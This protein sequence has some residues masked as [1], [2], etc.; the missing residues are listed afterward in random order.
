MKLVHVPAAFIDRAWK[1]GAHKLSEACKYS[2]DEITIDQLKLLLSRS[3][4]ILLAADDD[5]RKVGWCVVRVEQMPNIRAL[6]VCSLY[7]PH[8]GF[9]ALF[10]ELMAFAESQGCS[11][12]RCAAK[13]AQARLYQRKLGFEPVYQILRVKLGE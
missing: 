11:E 12:I 4:R 1:D 5:D 8:I 6:H 9:D 3:E 10:P 7:A 2:G 13:P